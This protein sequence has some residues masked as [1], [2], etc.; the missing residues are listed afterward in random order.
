MALPTT[1]HPFLTFQ[2][3]ETFLSSRVLHGDG[4]PVLVNVGVATLSRPIG[5]DGLP[6]SQTVFSSKLVLEASVVILGLFV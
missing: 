3:P 2:Y 1:Y 4:L 6:L 5:T